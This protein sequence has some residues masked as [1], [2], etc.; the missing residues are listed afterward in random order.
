MKNLKCATCVLLHIAVVSSY[1]RAGNGQICEVSDG[2]EQMFIQSCIEEDISNII[3]TQAWSAF[4][5]AF[6][7]RSPDQVT[8]EDFDAYFNVIPL[9]VTPDSVL[10]WSGTE[11][12]VKFIAQK[13]EHPICSSFSEPASKIIGGLSGSWCTIE[14]SNPSF[15]F[16]AAFSRLLGQSAEGIVFWTTTTKSNR[17]GVYYENGFFGKYELPALESPR[18]RRLVVINVHPEDRGEAC[19]GE[20][21]LHTLQSVV[22][23]KMLSFRC[24]DV[25][26]DPTSLDMATQISLANEVYGIIEEERSGKLS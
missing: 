12:L 4:S 14:D 11:E 24:T 7:S 8:I 19:G 15:M 5:S 3:C 23:S 16:W 22:E 1:F 13:T 10:F 2:L 21:T 6:A 18:V 20:E 26:G 9:G 25:E 17:T